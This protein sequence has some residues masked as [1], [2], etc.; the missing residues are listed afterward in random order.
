MST[1]HIALNRFGYGI[2]KGK[3]VPDDPKRSL[4]REMDAFEASPAAL[5]GREDTSDRAGEIL[6]TLRLQRLERRAM[7]L[8]T[9]ADDAVQQV[10][11][12]QL[13]AARERAGPL[14]DLPEDLR[15][16]FLDGGRIVRRDIALRINI[17][18]ASDTPFIERLVHFW[19]N[20]FS[21]S[22][23]KAGTPHQVGNH[24]FSAIRPRVL[25]KFSDLLKAAVLHPAMLIYLD[26]F[27]SIGPNSMVQRRFRRRGLNENLAREIM[28]LHTLGVNGGYSQ[29]DVTGFA[30]ALTGWS[31]SGLARLDRI[32]QPQPGGAVF[33]VVAHE[34]GT[35]T[36]LGKTYRSEGA[37]QALDVLDDLATHP[38][39][40]RFIATKLARHFAGDEPPE[41]LVS[42]L[43]NDFN[44]TGG[45]LASLTRRLVEAPECWTVGP[46]KYRQPQEWLISVLRFAGAGALED[47]RIANALK[48]LGQLPWGAPS[49]AGYDDIEGSWA[50]P[51]ALFRRVDLAERIA[52][53]VPADGLLQRAERAFPDALS[54]HTRLW[55]SRA[56]SDGQALGLLLVSP[57]MMRR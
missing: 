21:V 15:N 35:R 48:Q 55:L 19:S 37:Q 49:P 34:P 4:L 18:V 1:T 38:S 53:I 42:R 6:E 31:I 17:A 8:R 39:T 46:V 10:S 52:R 11:E 23:R 14:A 41:S 2:R 7:R 24:E 56:E 50:G 43:E 54:D 45:D 47:R 57:E 33:A 5:A 26:Q 13:M 16:A 12:K 27:Q 44:R 28:E 3:V 20:H 36:I 30:R 9:M 51:D 40:A 22:A 32:A 25:G 29:D